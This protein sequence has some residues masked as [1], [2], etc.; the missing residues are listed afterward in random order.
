MYSAFT[1]ALLPAVC[2]CLNGEQY[3]QNMDMIRNREACQAS[4]CCHWNTEEPGDPSF[5]GEGRCWSSI[6]QS[7]CTDMKREEHKA[8]DREFEKWMTC[9]REHCT[10]PGV[11]FNDCW[12]GTPSEPCTC[13]T[14]SA[15]VTGNTMMFEGQKY[16]EYTCCSDG[17]SDSDTSE[18]CGDC[19]TNWLAIVIAVSVVIA[20]C[21][22]CWGIFCCWVCKCCCFAPSAQT[23]TISSQSP[24]SAQQAVVV[25]QPVGQ[26]APG[27]AVPAVAAPGQAVPT[28]Q[29]TVVQP[30]TVTVNEENNMV[31]QATY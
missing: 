16:Y 22:T 31:S 7:R 9:S 23:M 20:C 24:V 6:G 15:R 26:L 18:N 21:S 29:A 10:S 3:C 8:G 28:V 2:L 30:V 19:C 11:Y 14:G 13:S 1:L 27:Q 5:N 12:A 25:G 4:F 17:G